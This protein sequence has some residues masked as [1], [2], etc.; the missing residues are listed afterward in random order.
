MR[1]LLKIVGWLVAG[2]VVVVAV[3]VAIIF[4]R[5]NAALKKNHTV[6]V[7]PVA[8]P[9]GAGALARG[10]HLAESR[11]CVDCHGADLGGA[12]VVESGAMGV[13]FGPNLTAGEGVRAGKF[14]NDDWVR[15]IRHGVG[16]DGRP[17]FLMPSEEYQHLG[18]DDLGAL[19]AYMKSVA[20]VNRP[21][22]PVQLGPIARMLLATGKMK[23]CADV[24]DHASIR[25]PSVTPGVTMDYGRYVAV[26]C[27][28]CHGPNFSGGKIEIGPPDWPPAANLTPHES[29]R[30]SKWTEQDFMRTI[31]TGKRPDG[32]EV[33]PVMP[34]AFA[35]LDDTELKAV[36]LY[37][38]S[39]PAA[40][41]GAR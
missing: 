17:L 1:K 8:I 20:P 21:S 22:V 39:L 7:R 4:T 32:A 25:P 33:N 41:T 9:T 30:L 28:G 15:A 14:N 5:S 24:I 36:W 37:L 3:A 10:K 34:R 2:L 29:S 12:K 26:G 18:D 6:A 13:W 38:K 31:R 19:I 23:L 16:P 27:I 35:N 40:V 11:G